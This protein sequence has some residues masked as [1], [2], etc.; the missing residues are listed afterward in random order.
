MKH[1]KIFSGILLLMLVAAFLS[2]GC[3]GPE[4]DAAVKE[5][6][7]PQGHDEDGHEKGKAHGEKE[8]AVPEAKAE[9]NEGGAKE[10]DGGHADEQVVRLSDQQLEDFNI[11]LATIQPGKISTFIELPGEIAVNG[12]RLAHVVPRVSGV[13]RN[14]LK[15]LGDTVK[16]GEVLAELESQELAEL[17]VAYFSA[18]ERHALAEELFK[19][20]EKLWQK[21]ISAE[22]DFLTARQTLAEAR[23]ALQSAEQKL[24]ALGFTEE[25]LA[26]Q[27][28]Q[29]DASLTRYA[30]TAPFDGTVIQKHLTL[31]ETVKDDAEVFIV[32]DLGRVWVDINVYPKDLPLVRTG[33]AVTI[34][35]GHQQPTG[36]GTIDYLGP[37]IGE[38]TRTAPARVILDNKDG[39]WRPG[40]FITA[41][42]AVGSHDVALMVPRTAL[43]TIEE[44]QVVFVRT[45][46]GFEPRNVGL[47][48]SDAQHVEI[49]D[50][51]K[52]G[53]TYAAKGAFT[54]KAQLSKG[55]F[56]DGHSNH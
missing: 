35:P 42:I 50:G 26:K 21:Q 8:K 9:H 17:K 32:A 22:Q 29:H 16:A 40:T 53:L 36:Q 34:D 54:L 3:G 18:R 48:R 6:A 39:R 28:K 12:D 47:G 7:A 19:R 5:H 49:V 27:A 43:Q 30:L 24:H 23:I 38:T 37:L 41:R 31:G 51:L 55:A 20:E 52:A 44:R 1:N 25:Q 45:P 14:V 15:K 56:G 2:G 46:E 10:S 4:K 33:Q 13:V 11:E